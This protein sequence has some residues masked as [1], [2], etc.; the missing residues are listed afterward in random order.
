VASCAAAIARRSSS[1][2]GAGRSG[3][4]GR[5]GAGGRDAAERAERALDVRGD[6][7]DVEAAE[8][9]G[10]DPA[11]LPGRGADRVLEGGGGVALAVADG[12]EER[13]QRGGDAVDLA[14]ADDG[15]GAVDRVREAVE[16]PRDLGL[17]RPRQQRLD[18]AQLL[19]GLL[20]EEAAQ[21]GIGDGHR[22][23]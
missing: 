14:E 13:L 9:A 4:V 11:E 10:D 23:R 5:L 21:D 17:G 1:P 3:G 6:G 15:R 22:P 20:L 19:G 18:G 16:L 2:A 7:G 8:H 12:A